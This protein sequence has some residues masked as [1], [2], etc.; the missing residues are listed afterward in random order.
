MGKIVNVKTIHTIGLK[1]TNH[2]DVWPSEGLNP[3]SQNEGWKK[4]YR[5]AVNAI[6]ERDTLCV[7][8]IELERFL[9]SSLKWWLGNAD[10]KGIFPSTFH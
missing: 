7:F 8:K 4:P 5:N 2:I 6:L 9:L 3:L 1:E 10:I